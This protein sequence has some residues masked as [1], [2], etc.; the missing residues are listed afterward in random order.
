MRARDQDNV[1]FGIVTELV[2]SAHTA[3]QDWVRLPVHLRRHLYCPSPRIHH[4]DPPR[5][6][7]NPKL[8]AVVGGQHAV[9][10]REVVPRG[11]DAVESGLGNC[12][13]PAGFFASTTSIAL[14]LRS[15]K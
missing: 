1:I 4:P 11:I 10:T 9:G 8:R 3:Y 2:G 15:V 14:L 7:S 6:V 5:A 13:M 12:V